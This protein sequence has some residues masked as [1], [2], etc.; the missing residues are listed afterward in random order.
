MDT[1]QKSPFCKQ[2][3]DAIYRNLYWGY[4]SK[5][6]SPHKAI[7]RCYRFGIINSQSMFSTFV[8]WT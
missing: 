8:D 6:V 7:V 2:F 1:F 4:E 5:R 3:L